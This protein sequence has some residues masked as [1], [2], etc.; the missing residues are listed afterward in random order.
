MDWDLAERDRLIELLMGITPAQTIPVLSHLGVADLLADGPRKVDDLA[1]SLGAHAMTLYRLLRF[2]ASYGVFTEVGPRTFALT[3]M[4]AYLRSDAPGT[5]HWRVDENDAAGRPWWPW[6]EWLETVRTGEPVYDRVNGRSWWE[7]LASNPNT[8]AL[9]DQAQRSQA[10]LHTEAIL[11]LL[12]LSGRH[13]AVEVGAG[14]ASWLAAVLMAYP[15]MTGIAFDKAEAGP[16]A[17]GRLKEVGLDGR[18][19]VVIGDF[20]NSIPAGDV[21]LVANVLHDWD[22]DRAAAILARCRAALEPDGLLV[23]IDRI[24][25][26]DDRRDYGKMFDMS[27][28]LNLGGRERTLREFEV[29]LGQVGLTLIRHHRTNLAIGVLEA[30]IEPVRASG[31]SVPVTP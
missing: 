8:R 23:I 29:L 20:F 24:L 2:A 16:A 10:E 12:D 13:H 28:L 27:M 22:D 3:P 11:P 18:A 4:A 15:K 25:P 14:E 26:D 9:F 19:E 31:P 5:L 21:L 1:E 17:E 7:G 30:Q 6:E